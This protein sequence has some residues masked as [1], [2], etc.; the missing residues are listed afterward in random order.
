M[1]HLHLRSNAEAASSQ[2]ADAG[3]SQCITVGNFILVGV[4]VCAFK[5][6]KPAKNCS[7][8]QSLTLAGFPQPEFCPMQPAELTVGKWGPALRNYRLQHQDGLVQGQTC[9]VLRLAAA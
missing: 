8:I 6:A 7:S 9:A 2:S 4:K 1:G 3:I 5:G